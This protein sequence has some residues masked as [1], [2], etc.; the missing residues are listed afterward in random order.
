MFSSRFN[1]PEWSKKIESQKYYQKYLEDA[2]AQHIIKPSDILLNNALRTKAL[3]DWYGDEISDRLSYVNSVPTDI[4][5]FGVG[6]APLRHLTKYGGIPYRPSSKPWPVTE[7]GVTYTFLAQFCFID[8]NDI[9]GPLPG[10]ILLIFAKDPWPYFSD[11]AL[12]YEWYNL[13]IKESELIQAEHC[14]PPKWLFFT[15]Y[16][17]LHRTVDYPNFDNVFA[18]AHLKSVL[19][20]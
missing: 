5:I 7:T 9:V 13:D 8:S 6:E 3:Y 1:F 19:R 14:P 10:D 2:R 4:C 16:G 11:D 15:G 17:L 20:P 12:Y 18:R